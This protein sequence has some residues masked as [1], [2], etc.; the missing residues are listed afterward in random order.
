[1][2]FRVG[3]QRCRVVSLASRIMAKRLERV[4]KRFGPKSTETQRPTPRSA[5]TPTSLGM[6][7]IM[8]SLKASLAAAAAVDPSLPALLPESLILFLEILFT[9]LLSRCGISAPA[10]LGHAKDIGSSAT[11]SARSAA[12]ERALALGHAAGPSI[13]RAATPRHTL[14]NTRRDLKHATLRM[15]TTSDAAHQPPSAYSRPAARR[16]LPLRPQ[17]HLEDQQMEELP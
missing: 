2:I 15:L 8:I 4:L 17:C 9:A 16:R 6:T 3:G 12:A 1:M 11:T 7:G 14:L 5:P 10:L 13:K